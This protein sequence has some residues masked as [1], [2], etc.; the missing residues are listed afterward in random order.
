MGIGNICFDIMVFYIMYIY[1]LILYGNDWIINDCMLLVF[2]DYID[3][4]L[5]VFFYNLYKNIF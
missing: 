4:F 1:K 5:W 2:V 3:F